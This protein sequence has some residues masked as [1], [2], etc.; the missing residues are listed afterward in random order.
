MRFLPNWWF[1]YR[2]LDLFCIQCWNNAIVNSWTGFE[3]SLIFSFSSLTISFPLFN[4]FI[5]TDTKSS[6][7][8]T[9]YFSLSFICNLSFGIIL[10]K[11]QLFQWSSESLLMLHFSAHSMSIPHP[12]L[13]DVNLPLKIFPSRKRI[14]KGE[15]THFNWGLSWACGVY[16]NFICVDLSGSMRIRHQKVHISTLSMSLVGLLPQILKCFCLTVQWHLQIV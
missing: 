13:V 4:S 14:H 6:S 8:S 1:L 12:P 9:F 5:N 7:V 10:S 3:F 15:K 11:N 16:V 2:F